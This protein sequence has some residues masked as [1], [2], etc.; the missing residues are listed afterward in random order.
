MHYRAYS[1]RKSHSYQSHHW[2]RGQPN[3][4]GPVGRARRP[5][6]G[7]HLSPT[8]SAAAGAAA[9]GSGG[10]RAVVAPLVRARAPSEPPGVASSPLAGPHAVPRTHDARHRS[11]GRPGPPDL[12]SSSSSAC[13]PLAC[14]TRRTA[15]R[16][17]RV[18]CA[19]FGLV[20]GR[21]GG[22]RR[23]P[24]LASRDPGRQ[25]GARRGSPPEFLKRLERLELPELLK[26]LEL[27]PSPPPLAP[28]T[29]RMKT[30]RPR[31]L[32]SAGPRRPH[33]G[34]SQEVTSAS[35]ARTGSRQPEPA[36]RSSC[37]GAT[38]SDPRRR[39]PAR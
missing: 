31:A 23:R 28:S 34:T 7:R 36:R 37:S 20:A 6:R 17:G 13:R 18:M 14:A 1:G 3:P 29:R 2:S 26:R 25:P 15:R 39:T 19:R 27:R 16:V 33:G 35:P 22:P 24:G 38:P 21:G 30:K 11:A 12:T 9:S 10:P 4:V 5:S 8:M 32:A